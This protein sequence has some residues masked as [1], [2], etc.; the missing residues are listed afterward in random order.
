MNAE[1][2]TY[3][4]KMEAVAYCTAGCK[5]GDDARPLEQKELAAHDDKH[6]PSKVRTLVRTLRD[7]P[8]EVRQQVLKFFE[9]PKAAKGGVFAS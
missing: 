9:N 8:E 5:C 6:L 3:K 2:P 4:R 1:H 7:A